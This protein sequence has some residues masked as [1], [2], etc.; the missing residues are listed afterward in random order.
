MKGAAIGLLMVIGWTAVL[1][2]AGF[3]IFGA[4]TIVPLFGV[5]LGFGLFPFIY[6]AGAAPAFVTAASFEF[7]FRHWGLTRSFAAT[8]ILGATASVLWMVGIFLFEGRAI[9]FGTHYVTFALAMA[10]ALPAALMP[11]AR[12]AKDRRRWR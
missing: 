1:P 9:R 6:A 4:L 5:F 8:V 11:L 2:L 3:V 10:G 7:V 12:F